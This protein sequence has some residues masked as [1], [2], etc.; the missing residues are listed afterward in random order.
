MECEESLMKLIKYLYERE[1]VVECKGK[2]KGRGEFFFGAK[3]MYDLL[4]NPS[5]F[6]YSSSPPS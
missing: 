2:D 5:H 1:I 4:R 3:S 6:K